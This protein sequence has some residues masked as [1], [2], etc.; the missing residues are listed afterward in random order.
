MVLVDSIGTIQ[1]LSR[2]SE[3]FGVNHY[4]FFSQVTHRCSIPWTMLKHVRRSKRY[5]KCKFVH[6]HAIH[7]VPWTQL[8]QNGPQCH[9]WVE[10]ISLGFLSF[11]SGRQWLSWG[12]LLPWRLHGSCP[13]GIICVSLGELGIPRSAHLA[14][15]PWTSEVAMNNLGILKWLLYYVEQDEICPRP[16]ERNPC[17]ILQSQT[18]VFPVFPYIKS[19]QTVGSEDL[20][21]EAAY[22]NGQSTLEFHS[23][24][25]H[26]YASVWHVLDWGDQTSWYFGHHRNILLLESGLYGVKS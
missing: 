22:R 7:I 10:S 15:G 20:P 26:I 16:P 8:P 18:P 1:D 12:Q 6:F 17:E 3:N 14:P 21:F 13:F 19:D 23:W 24:K 11:S 9:S 5:Q 4:R 25:Q 2:P